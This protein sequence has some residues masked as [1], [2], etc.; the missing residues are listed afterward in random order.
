MGKAGLDEGWGRSAGHQG[1]LSGWGEGTGAAG[2]TLGRAGAGLGAGRRGARGCQP[3]P[4]RGVLQGCAPIRTALTNLPLAASELLPALSQPSPGPCVYCPC[5]RSHHLPLSHPAPLSPFSLSLLLQAMALGVTHILTVLSILQ[6]MLRV[7]EW[8][9]VAAQE[10]MQEYEQ[11]QQQEMAWLLEME[12][13]SKE[14]HGLA[15]ES[16]LLAACQHWWFWVC[17]EILLILFGI[18]W[19]PR[20]RSADCDSGSQEGN[21]SSEE[22]ESDK[23]E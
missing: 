13:K 22:E 2:S 16:V 8:R 9:D 10:L 19:L 6:S 1:E 20:Q 12:L 7:G 15:H 11:Q 5:C 4:V 17:A 23:E 14:P 3:W 18:Y 21:S